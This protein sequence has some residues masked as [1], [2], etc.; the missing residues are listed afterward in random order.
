[1]KT[2]L[3]AFFDLDGTL[4][5]RNQPPAAVDVEAMRTFKARG[6]YLFLC[7]GRSTGYLYQEILDI[8]FDGIIAGAGAYVLFGDRLLYRNSVSSD[9]LTPIQ[10]AFE[11]A[12]S[13]LIMET[14]RCMV[15][16]ASPRANRLIPTYPRIRTAEE[17]RAQYRNE[18][19]SKLT[20]YGALPPAIFPFVE[21][22]LDVILHKT[23]NLSCYYFKGGQRLSHRRYS[24]I[25]S[26]RL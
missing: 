3:A 10:R 5:T 2:P 21:S 25:L 11:D 14:E 16:L 12:E 23:V 4:A 22:H 9:V 19:V 6:N 13:T 26:E 8:G 17:W 18:I 20:V 7:T 15:Q 24:N 1:M